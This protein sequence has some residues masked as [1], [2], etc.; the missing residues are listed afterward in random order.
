MAAVA[1]YLADTSVLTRVTK[2]TVLEQLQPLFEKG[3]VGICSIVEMELIFEHGTPVTVTA[4]A[5]GFED[6]NT[7]RSPMMSRSARSKSGRRSWSAPSIA[8]SNFPI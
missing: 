8:P 1:K 5:T 7:F 6:S 3:N 4:S 2:P